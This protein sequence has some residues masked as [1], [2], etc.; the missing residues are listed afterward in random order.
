MERADTQEKEHLNPQKT[1][2]KG[3]D[4]YVTIKN[5]NANNRNLMSNLILQI[6]FE[7]I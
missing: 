3:R 5:P 4:Y 7:V 1:K 6:K 2:S